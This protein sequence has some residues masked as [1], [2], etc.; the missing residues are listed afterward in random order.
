MLLTVAR[1]FV[2]LHSKLW[3]EMI[4][5]YS[6]Q[7][8]LFMAFVALTGCRTSQIASESV[9]NLQ[10]EDVLVIAKD[11][12]ISEGFELEKYNITEFVYED[13]HNKW[14]VVFEKK[15]PTPP[16]GHFLVWVDDRTKEAILM[17]G[18]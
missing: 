13:E 7:L 6:L 14:T 15:P 10:Q 2:A 17:H 8:V 12:A 4:R 9:V 3:V 18:E 1:K 5:N 11:K 16:G